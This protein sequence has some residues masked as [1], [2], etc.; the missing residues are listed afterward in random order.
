MFHQQS[1]RHL[2]NAH[3]LEDT[4]FLTIYATAKTESAATVRPNDNNK[5]K[6]VATSS[7]KLVG[8]T[9]VPT[10]RNTQR[11]IMNKQLTGKELTVP[12]A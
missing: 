5:N 11:L 9:R 2:H 4:I 10:E 7:I 6:I 3:V 12:K 8:D 1:T